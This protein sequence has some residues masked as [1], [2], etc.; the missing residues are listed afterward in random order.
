ME[1]GNFP[2]TLWLHDFE[3]YVGD[4]V[5]VLVRQPHGAW[6]PGVNWVGAGVIGAWRVGGAWPVGAWLVDALKYTVV[7]GVL[8]CY[9]CSAMNV[10]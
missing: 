10:I 7:L 3:A 1:M 9:S 8:G 2:L 4:Q 5:S 6:V